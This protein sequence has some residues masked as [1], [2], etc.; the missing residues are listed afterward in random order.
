M[1]VIYNHELIIEELL[2][3]LSLT[4]DI[5]YCGVAKFQYHVGCILGIQGPLGLKGNKGPKGDTGPP[6]S[7]GSA[8]MPTNS[9][10]CPGCPEP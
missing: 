3:P 2:T 8:S 6:G 5:I 7:T 10:L 4:F 9:T 1:I